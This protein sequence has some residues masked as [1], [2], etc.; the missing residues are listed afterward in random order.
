MYNEVDP[1]DL[2]M[3]RNAEPE[4]CSGWFWVTFQ[5]LR[6]H[7]DKLFYPLKD[8][9]TKFPDLTNVSYLKNM[10]KRYENVA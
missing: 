3:I 6:S 4:K 5:E 9:L 7:V 2:T 8:F 10:I 1:N